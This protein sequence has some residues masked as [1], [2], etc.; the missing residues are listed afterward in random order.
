MSRTDVIAGLKVLPSLAWRVLVGG[1]RAP[2]SSIVNLASF[3][4]GSDSASVVHRLFGRFLADCHNAAAAS[5]RMMAAAISAAAKPCWIPATALTT[6]GPTTWPTANAAV[7]A[8]MKPVALAPPRAGFT[9]PG[10]GD[11]HEGAADQQRRDQDCVQAGP[12]YGQHHAH[13]HQQAGDG[14]HPAVVHCMQPARGGERRQRRCR[15]EHRPGPAEHGRIGDEAPCHRRQECG[16][17]DVAEIER[18][19]VAGQQQPVGAP[20][21]VLRE[22]RYGF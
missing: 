7:I 12:N 6:S 2:Q 4:N 8:P 16:R 3:C 9:Q 19:V 15:A 13:G 14:P 21:H 20:C 5:A 10:H 1:C 17:D 11:H 22:R 18:A